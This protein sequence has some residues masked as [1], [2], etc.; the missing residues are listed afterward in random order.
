MDPIS[1]FDH[2][3]QALDG[4]GN[5]A[6]GI[7]FMK[8]YGGANPLDPLRFINH[9]AKQHSYKNSERVTGNETIK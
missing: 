3:A 2:R 4:Q 6:K 8:A 1:I 9:L 5:P 7:D